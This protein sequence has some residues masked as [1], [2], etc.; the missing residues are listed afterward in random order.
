[1]NWCVQGPHKTL[2]QTCLW[3][4]SVEIWVSSVLSWEQDLWLQQTL[5]AQCVSS[6]IKLPSRQHK[7]WRTIIPNKFSH[8]C[9]SSRA[10][11][12]FPNLGMGM[13]QRNPKE[14]DFETSGIW[15]KN[16]H[17]TGETVTSH[18]ESSNKTV[19]EPG[20]RGKEQWPQKK[21]SWFPVSIQESLAEAWVDSVLL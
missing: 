17:R 11:N 15:L 8:C 6:T 20:P 1:M 10:H 19:C 14:L 12:R 2:S 21:L 7:N 16:F 3:V 18:L 9:E 13:G 4:S 5:E